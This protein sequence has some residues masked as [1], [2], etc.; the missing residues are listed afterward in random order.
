MRS[1]T[2]G[3]KTKVIP[4]LVAGAGGHAVQPAAPNI[5]T[6]VGNVTY[7]MGAPL[8]GTTPSAF[9]NY[10][11]GYLTVTV[12]KTSIQA[13]YTLVEEGHRQPLE[14]ITITL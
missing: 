14:T 2:V 10:G 7:A 3:V 13:L 6:T 8:K 12:T 5:N 9:S 4:F 11:Y 1:E